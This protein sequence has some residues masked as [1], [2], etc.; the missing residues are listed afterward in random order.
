MLNHNTTYMRKAVILAF[1][2]I[3][4]SSCC[5][6]VIFT[7]CEKQK[8]LISAYEAYYRAS[9]GLLDSLDSHYDWVDAFDP[10]DYYDARYKLDSLRADR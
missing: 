7:E 9:E 4:L 5:N 1:V 6:T 2:A 8:E 3:A 10:M